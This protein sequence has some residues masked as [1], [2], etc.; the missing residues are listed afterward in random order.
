[1]T[2]VLDTKPLVAAALTRV[3]R[4][5]NGGTSP[6]QQ[7]DQAQ[8]VTE[9]DGF[10]VLLQ[11]EYREEQ[12]ASRFGTK[13]RKQFAALIE[14]IRQDR[15]NLIILWE[16]DRGARETE[17]WSRFLN[18]CR[19][20]RTLVHV[21]THR[22]TYDVRNGRDWRALMEDGV[23]A[24]Y[25][26]EKL[27]V[28]I[29]RGHDAA[30][31]DGKPGGRA[32][33]GYMRVYDGPNGKLGQTED[34]LWKQLPNEDA[35]VV[36]EIIE[37]IASQVPI[38]EVH[39]DLAAKGVNIPRATVRAI[40]TCPAYAALRP[41]GNGGYVQGRWVSIVDEATWRR[42]KAVLDGQGGTKPGHA[43]WLLS[44]VGDCACGAS[45]SWKGR[46]A[47]GNKQA[48]YFCTSC[49]TKVNAEQ[50]DQ[51]VTALA[52]GRMSQPDAAAFLIR[53]T[54][55][56][57]NAARL[58]VQRLEGKLHRHQDALEA[59]TTEVDE[60]MERDQIRR[61]TPKLKAAKQRA[62]K[63]STPPALVDFADALGNFDAVYDRWEAA[64]LPARKAVLRVI[65]ERIELHR[66]AHRGQAAKDR[67][68]H[69]FA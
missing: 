8:Q 13:P 48:A 23:D 58:E 28:N 11:E 63:L 33:Y 46:A 39:R 53:D 42:A 55:E 64:S 3:S 21:I 20:T 69:T 24:A 1:M 56:E 17:A 6:A 30:R 44:Q 45:R 12:S 65:F 32:P 40:A 25:F 18:V 67:I 34:G 37:R 50:A 36:R 47:Q 26:S 16:V 27:S 49:G 43:V 59:A 62:E 14:D 15:Y 57:A 19:S 10:P 41:D 29:R 54:S 35:P 61:V 9:V 51:H 60:D 5:V 22:R 2:L 38:N 4:K 7:W 52:L 68:T 66:A 31:N